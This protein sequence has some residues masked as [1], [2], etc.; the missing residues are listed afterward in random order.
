[1]KERGAPHRVEP[2]FRHAEMPDLALGNQIADRARDIL[3]RHIGIDPVLIIEV[4][5]IGP[6]PLE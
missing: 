4:D 3:D 2:G 6:Q 1:M 5:M